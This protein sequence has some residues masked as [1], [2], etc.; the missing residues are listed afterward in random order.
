MSLGKLGEIGGFI[1]G[2]PVGGAIGGV[3]GGLV[4]GLFGGGGPSKEEV[5]EQLKDELIG[6][7][8]QTTS[9]MQRK[10]ADKFLK[11]VRDNMKESQE[12]I[13]E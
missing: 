10:Q 6:S 8:L 1:A 12:N 13:A 2:G 3:V 7:S 4:G 5:L 9:S 11:K